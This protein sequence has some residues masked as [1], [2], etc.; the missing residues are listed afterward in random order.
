MQVSIRPWTDNKGTV[1]S[2]L[3]LQQ[4]LLRE[5][6]RRIST[7]QDTNLKT[8]HPGILLVFHKGRKIKIF[9]SES[10]TQTRKKLFKAA[11]KVKKE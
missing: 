8:N 2:P 5:T 10:L 11:L 9:I 7:E 1:H 3:P 4:N 6:L